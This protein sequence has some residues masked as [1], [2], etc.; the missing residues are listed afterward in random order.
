MSDMA[1]TDPGE[2][3]QLLSLA[4][5]GDGNAGE[6]VMQ[7]LYTLLR[8][9]AARHLRGEH[10]PQALSPT[11]L[12]HETY[13]ELFPSKLS[14]WNDRQHFFAYASTAMRNILTDQARRRM[15]AKRGGRSA[16]SL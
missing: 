15:A 1:T 3:T 16:A 10:H 9:Q 12:V 6:Q 14:G 8:Q 2:I 13:L 4:A 7:V 11:E 5:K